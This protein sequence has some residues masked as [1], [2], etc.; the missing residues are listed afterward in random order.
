MAGIHRRIDADGHAIPVRK[1]DS[2]LEQRV[3][4]P[5]GFRE[6]AS[7]WV[8]GCTQAFVA[9]LIFMQDGDKSE[10]MRQAVE[11]FLVD[12][13]GVIDWLDL[14]LFR[15]DVDRV[16]IPFCIMETPR[17]IQPVMVIGIIECDTK[18]F[19]GGKGCFDV[20]RILPV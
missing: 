6:L 14:T 4:L 16:D 7:Y 18:A 12:G 13:D 9:W 10:E 5:D 3:F 15:Q 20:G 19:C 17:K 1:R 11:L 2:G 8:F